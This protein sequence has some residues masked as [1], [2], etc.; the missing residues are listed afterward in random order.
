MNAVLFPGQGSQHVGMGQ[1]L[2]ANFKSAKELFE[3]GSEVLQK[4]LKK[5]CFDG[6]E[7]DLVLTENTQPALLLVSYATFKILSEISPV[8]FSFGAGHSLGEYSALVASGVLPLTSALK[9]VRLRGRAMQAAVPVGSGSMLAVLGLSDEDVAK[10]CTWAEKESGL[11]PLEPA[12]FNAPGQVVISGSK[13]I[14]DWL[15]A[16]FDSEKVFGEKKRA[17]LIPLNVSAPFHCSLMKPAQEKMEPVLKDIP[18]GVPA[19]AVVQN[20]DAKANTQ[21]AKIRENLISQIS[22]PVKW[23]QSVTQMK[24]MGATRYV[25]CGP[26]KVLSNLMKKIDSEASTFNI[27]SLEDLKRLEQES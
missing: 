25:E 14:C 17:K 27:H 7:S 21:P 19:W 22:A 6:P 4:N 5:L 20:V 11:T 15:Q 12:N 8:K 10:L 3:E 26:S 24:Q 2:F 16:N 13:T 1:F 18:F 23:A 9:A